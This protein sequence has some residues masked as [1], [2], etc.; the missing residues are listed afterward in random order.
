[1][2]GD[3]LQPLKRTKAVHFM[4]SL[5]NFHGSRNPL[6]LAVR[7]GRWTGCPPPASGG[8]LEWDCR[9]QAHGRRLP[10]AAKEN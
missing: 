6:A 5:F 7:P 4:D 9:K 2:E 10:S 3:S 1:M 8:G